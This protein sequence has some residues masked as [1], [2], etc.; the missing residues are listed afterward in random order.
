MC[1]RNVC[2]QH[3]ALFFFVFGAAHVTCTVMYFLP[4]QKILCPLSVILL[5]V[6]FVS[7]AVV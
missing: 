3:F 4:A 7:D 1:E 6:V 5:L 2:S